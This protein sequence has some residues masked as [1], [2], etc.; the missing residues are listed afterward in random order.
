MGIGFTLKQL[1]KD[2]QM[3]VKEIA[4]KTE[5]PASTL[6]SIVN[7]DNAAVKSDILI[8]IAST[9]DVSVT[10]LMGVPFAERFNI[11]KP[12]SPFDDFGSI[13]DKSH[14]S[15]IDNMKKLNTYGKE[16]AAKRVEEL[17]HIEKY[18]K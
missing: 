10:E 11:P 14:I 1:L 15:I 7:R 5:I 9:L 16:E 3:T 12:G 18:S 17:T 2:K 4:D 8:K 6:Y 13:D